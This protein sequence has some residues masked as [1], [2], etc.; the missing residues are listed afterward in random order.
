MSHP[1]SELSQWA[2]LNGATF[3]NIAPATAGQNRGSGL[4]ATQD[5]NSNSQNGP[6]MIVPRDLVLSKETVELLSKSDKDLRSLLE[7]LGDFVHTPRGAILTFLLYLRTM[8]TARSATPAIHLGTLSPFN[9]YVEFLP[10]ELLPTFWNEDEIAFLRGT[11]LSA[12]LTAKL[13]SLLREFSILSERTQDISWC[14]SFWHA[15]PTTSPFSPLELDDWKIVDSMYRSRA[16]EF[17]GIGDAMVPCIDIANHASGSST[18]ALYEIDGE[19]NAVLLLR[20]GVRVG[21]EEEVTITYGDLKG[22]CEMLFSYGFIEDTMEDARE[23]FLPLDMNED[24][25][26]GP[27][28]KH[29]SKEVFAP[30][31][32]IYR[33]H[34]GK[35]KNENENE[36]ENEE[37][38]EKQEGKSSVNWHSEF[39]YLSIL[40]QEDGLDFA[41]AQTTTGERILQ[42]L[43]KGEHI[44]SLALSS[45]VDEVLKRDEYWELFHLR[46]TVTVLERVREQMGI[47]DSVDPEILRE[48]GGIEVRERCY[49]LA[50]RLRELEG[51]LMSE[52]VGELEKEIEELSETEVVRRWFEMHA[53]G[54]DEVELEQGVREQ[55]DE[56]FT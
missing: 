32:K 33:H 12:A 20:E 11:S 24:D 31:V 54:G 53:A 6:L 2:D 56:D 51:R 18:S 35:D 14:Q 19:G 55:D 36:N 25:P 42:M 49:D 39:L 21:E 3:H 17:P 5:L 30:G 9:Q 37:G 15:P 13:K 10:Q 26:L 23:L 45:F 34:E 8:N 46:A 47:L 28:K 41:V 7:A 48:E 40:N 29:I 44:P 22:A 43:W 1:I 50:V 38:K 52:A 27:A 16:L 4:I